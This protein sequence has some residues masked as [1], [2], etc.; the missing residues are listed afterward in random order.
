[1][2]RSGKTSRGLATRA[3]IVQVATEM[4]LD[5]G[6]VAT[7]VAAIAKAAGVSAQAVYLA[8]GSKSAI[9]KAAVDIAAAGDDEEI[10]LSARPWLDQ[11]KAC[12][13]AYAALD[14][15][16]EQI[17]VVT[18]RSS[19]IYEVIRAASAD[20]EVA[21]LAA[22]VTAQRLETSRDITALFSGKPGFDPAMT[23]EQA[24]AIGYMLFSP[25][26][27]RLLVDDCGWTPQQWRDYVRTT[28][29]TQMQHTEAVAAPT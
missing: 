23:T 12:P 20:P 4:F 1:M 11:V 14:I 16:V 10:A 22:D 15:V 6:Y 5:G 8:F 28:L 27:H 24:T 19:P 18:E 7:T 17:A 2:G 9:L 26:V 13:D 29:R 21:Q 3:R 25:E